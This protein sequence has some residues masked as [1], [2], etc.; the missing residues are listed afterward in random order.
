MIRSERLFAHL[1]AS[2]N[3]QLKPCSVEL[4][5]SC[6]SEAPGAPFLCQLTLSV[7]NNLGATEEN[8]DFLDVEIRPEASNPDPIRGSLVSQ[9]VGAIACMLCVFLFSS[10]C[11]CAHVTPCQ[12]A[13]VHVSSI[14][15]YPQHPMQITGRYKIP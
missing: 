12:T 15:P 6:G 2:S 4:A 7:M 8:G 1:E 5:V 9:S 13:Q 14:R 10:K 3:L 11:M